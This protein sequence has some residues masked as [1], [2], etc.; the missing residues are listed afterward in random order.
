[1]GF[2]V[3]ILCFSIPA[4]AV[5]SPVYA[6]L[7][8]EGIKKYAIPT[9]KAAI[10][11]ALE[12]TG[13]DALPG[14]SEKNVA[15]AK[16]EMIADCRTPFV[17]ERMKKN[18]VWRLT[19]TDVPVQWHSEEVKRDFEVI[20]DPTSGQLLS[21]FSI[22]D[23]VGSSDTLPEPT[24]IIAEDELEQRLVLFDGLPKKMPQISLIEAFSSCHLSPASAKIIRALYMNFHMRTTTHNDTWIIILR[25]TEYPMEPFGSLGYVPVNERNCML[26]SV[27]SE[28]G[29]LK[30][31]VTAPQDTD[32][33]RRRKGIIKDE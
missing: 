30:F 9:A 5:V 11:K 33:I 22:S 31:A 26:Y 21:V 19:F 27:D 8:S 1:M 23:E 18:D 3:I 16:L 25:G 15:E 7:N 17:A 28:T 10:S 4:V 29:F 13:F 20:L 2:I 6:Q 24:A 14:F 12:Y 32:L